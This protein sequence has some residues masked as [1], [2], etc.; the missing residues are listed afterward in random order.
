MFVLGRLLEL[1]ALLL[2]RR[3]LSAGRLLSFAV[4]GTVAAVLTNLQGDWTWLSLVQQFRS[5]LPVDLIAVLCFAAVIAGATVT[6]VLRHHFR[7][8]VPDPRVMLREAAGG[9]LMVCG[10]L[11]IPGGNDSLLVYGLPSGSPHALAGYVVMFGLMVVLLR[12][13]P[14]FRR[15][16]IWASPGR[17]V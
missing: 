10:A 2:S 6:A 9:A 11:L 5:G 12:I 1:G 17:G 3:H 16:A 15:W 14:L 13:T 4:L 8:V 7:F